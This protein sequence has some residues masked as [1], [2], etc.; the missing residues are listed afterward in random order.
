MSRDLFSMLFS[1]ILQLNLLKLDDHMLSYVKKW[2][3]RRWHPSTIL[4]FK[5]FSFWSR[6]CRRILC[7]LSCAKFHQN[8]TIFHEI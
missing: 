3:S 2:F 6:D 1:F 5:S 4:N 7:V 8:R